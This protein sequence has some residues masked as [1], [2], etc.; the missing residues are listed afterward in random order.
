MPLFLCFRSSEEYYEIISISTLRGNFCIW[1]RSRR[2]PNNWLIESFNSY[3]T[4]NNLE[5]VYL[6]SFKIPNSVIFLLN[7]PA[8]TFRYPTCDALYPTLHCP[9]CT[10]SI[11]FCITATRHNSL[12]WRLLEKTRIVRK[13]GY[14]DL[15]CCGVLFWQF[16]GV[17]SWPKVLPKYHNES[18]LMLKY[19]SSPRY[20]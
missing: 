15:P 16:N 8:V 19:M 13:Y 12:P 17:N 10:H 2:Y 7:K 4:L 18:S 1:T 9:A 11:N 6:V 3:H 20:A 14:L 5:K